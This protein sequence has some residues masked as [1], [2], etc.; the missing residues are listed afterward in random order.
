MKYRLDA[1]HFI[2]D[3][4]LETGSEVGDDTGIPFRFA[5]D[6]NTVR[7]DG[8]R[9]VVKKGDRML[10]SIAMTPL[11][12]EA[13]REYKERFGAEP[14][15]VDPTQRIPIM[16][17]VKSSENIQP[18]RNP[19]PKAIGPTVNPNPLKPGDKPPAMPPPGQGPQ[20]GAPDNRSPGASTPHAP[21]P[22]GE[23]K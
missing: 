20:P 9:V 14:P 13:K 21:S 15:D 12:D 5:R 7:P 1:P 23:K 19:I 16:G 18:G 6:S 4:Y 22:T 2:D 3:M 11:D 17:N 10:P 8:K